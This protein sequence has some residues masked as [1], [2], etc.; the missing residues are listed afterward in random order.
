MFLG[1]DLGT[2][3]IKGAVLD[4]ATYQ[5]SHVYRIP[6]PD[7][8]PGLP[9]LYREFD[10]GQVIAAVRAVLDRL[11]PYADRCEGIVMCSQMHGV[12]FCTATGEAR[13]N[14]I[15]WEDQR[16]LLPHPSGNGS[17]F[18]WVRACLD[19]SERSQLGN[20]LR[21]GMPSVLLSWYAQ[22]PSQPLAG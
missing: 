13:S 21:P 1:I 7:P 14:L 6:F 11:I 2:S 17:F 18:D 10:P 20:E 8:I 5:V 15:N 12:V 3:F 9:P 22:Q 19:T 16:G 4:L